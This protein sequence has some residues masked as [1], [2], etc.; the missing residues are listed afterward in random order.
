MVNYVTPCY[1]DLSLTGSANAYMSVWEFVTNDVLLKFLELLQIANK[2]I[3]RIFNY[4]GFIFRLKIIYS[5]YTVTLIQYSGWYLITKRKEIFIEISQPVPIAIYYE[6]RKKMYECNA[7]FLFL[8]K[9]S[10]SLNNSV[11]IQYNL[12]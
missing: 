7:V 6:E 12:K 4:I 1:V 11:H 9:Q 3:F 8:L 10:L 5:I 2:K